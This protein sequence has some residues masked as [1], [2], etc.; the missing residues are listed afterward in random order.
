MEQPF[1]QPYANILNIFTSFGHGRRAACAR[2]DALPANTCGAGKE[3]ARY[4]A[5][6]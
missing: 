5:Q 1:A 6:L 4:V 2:L 3:G